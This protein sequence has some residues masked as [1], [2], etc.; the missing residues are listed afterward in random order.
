MG[1]GFGLGGAYVV[2]FYTS[3]LYDVTNGWISLPS[4]HFGPVP[5]PLRGVPP[6][7][8]SW[9]SHT[10]PPHLLPSL[11]RTLYKRSTSSF[12]LTMTT[13]ATV[14]NALHSYVSY[15]VAHGARKSSFISL[16]SPR[17]ASYDTVYEKIN[18]LFVYESSND[19]SFLG[20]GSA[21]Q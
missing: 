11:H 2:L 6:W 17:C 8:L 15:M 13:T 21:W 3:W 12:L 18:Q 5:P 19:V 14:Q 10:H 16:P 9:I 1:L 7:T 4:E 20:L